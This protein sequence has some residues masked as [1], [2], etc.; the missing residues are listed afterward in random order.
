[1]NIKQALII[2][3]TVVLILSGSLT[4]FAD[5]I[6]GQ[7][8]AENEKQNR[9]VTEY[10]TKSMLENYDT[11][12]VQVAAGINDKI[13]L[14]SKSAILIEQTT[15]KVLYEEN[16][17][18]QMSPASIT[19]I[20][21]LLLI[22][23]DIEA[24]NLSLDS[25]IQCSEHAASM[26]GSQIWLEPGEQMSVNDLL[27]AVAIGS[28]NDATC[29]LGEAVA[30]SEEGFVTM[31]NNRAAELGMKNTVFKNCS[32]LDTDGHVST[33]RDIAIMSQELLKHDIIYNYTTVWM[34]TLRGGKTQLVNTNKLIR[35]YDGATGL[36]TGTTNNAGCCLSAS[37]TR[38]GLKLIA[39]IMGSDNSD[40]RFK[41]ARKLLD[42]GFANYEFAQI[43]LT[44]PVD[45]IGVTNGTEK[46]VK[47]VTDS[48]QSFLLPKGSRS[49]VT[50]EY[51]LP[52]NITSPVL[53]GDVIGRA[54]IILNGETIGE[55]E[56]RAEHG[57]DKMNFSR[58][59]ARMLKYTFKM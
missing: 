40:K 20:M 10:Y 34:D 3:S 36:K 42:M 17:D 14:E 50:I 38:N 16:A 44:L 8:I 29:A 39:V 57:V 21:S 30:G 24:G 19:K 55:A 37:A 46:T 48:S 18:I 6:E 33:A 45:N 11:G 15:G 25:M 22:V 53:E 35:F 28:A 47:L 4:A 9:I 27:K 51:N 43:E 56:I 41:S 26:G 2:I 59:F 5:G 58:A 32:G 49:A 1:M 13:E 31:M 12:E 7:P 52:E 54:N 23:E